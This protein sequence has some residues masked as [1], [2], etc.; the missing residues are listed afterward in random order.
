MLKC[1]ERIAANA[2]RAAIDSGD[3]FKYAKVFKELAWLEQSETLR[4]GDRQHY[5]QTEEL[6]VEELA[7]SLGKTRKQARKLLYSA[8]DA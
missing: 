8:A 2:H 4:A 7:D 3:P 6:L 5:K 1:R